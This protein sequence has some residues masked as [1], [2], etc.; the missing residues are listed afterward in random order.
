MTSSITKQAIDAM[1]AR[2]HRTGD[3]QLELV[4]DREPGLRVRAGK[5]TVT[6]SLLV[7]LRNGK[8]SRVTLG[9]WPLMSI[10]EARDAARLHRQQVM[11]G[12]DPNEVKQ[13]EVETAKRELECRLTVKDALD[14][15]EAI[16]LAQ[17]RHGP[18][19]RR[20][21]DGKRGIISDL[22]DRELA[23]L[24][25][26][27]LTSR[28]RELAVT[29]PTAGNRKLAHLKAFLNWCVNEDFI[30]TNVIDKVKKPG[31]EVPRTRCHSL[32]E[33]K[34][35]WAAAGRLGYPFG[36]MIRLLIVIPMRRE[37]IASL[38]IDELK[39]DWDEESG[40]GKWT[41]P[42]ERVKNGRALNVPLSPLATRIIRTVIDD[43]ARPKESRFLFTTTGTTSVS[44]FRKAKDRLDRYIHD[45][46]QK[47]ATKAGTMATEMPHWR[48]HDLRTSFATQAAE[49]LHIDISVVDRMLNHVATATTSKVARIYNMSEL[50]EQRREASNAWADLLEREVIEC[51]K[52]G[53]G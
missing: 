52:K 14:K 17:L 37:E 30:E 19:R 10:A 2:A 25:R 43:P 12:V 51:K 33:L 15:Y 27:E 1:A 46:R 18:E 36:P 35:I 47:A 42:G 34:E 44:G 38:P 29:S 41:I 28:I 13:A 32:D 20:S 26:A 3:A 39:I 9:T 24:T 4:D 22:V 16:K 7:R 8:R 50:F 31:R 53:T 23:S 6:W 5:R 11:E 49:I 48:V 21:L 40:E 45:A